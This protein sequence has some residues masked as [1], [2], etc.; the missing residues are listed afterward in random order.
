MP[1]THAFILQDAETLFTIL[2]ISFIY[3]SFITILRV[4]YIIDILTPINLQYF[5]LC[6][7]IAILYSMSYTETEFDTNYEVFVL[8]HY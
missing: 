1:R 7:S 5:F 3:S 4:L 6:F 8:H 2:H